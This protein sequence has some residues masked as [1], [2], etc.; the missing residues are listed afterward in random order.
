MKYLITSLLLLLPFGVVAQ[1]EP[2]TKFFGATQVCADFNIAFTT[3]MESGE[4]LLFKGQMAQLSTADTTMY[5]SQMFFFTNQDTGTWSL[6]GVYPDGTACLV[7]N[8]VGFTPYI[9][10]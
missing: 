4:S 2:E 8:G 9:G 6:I 3:A 5:T 1:E 10:D 7:G